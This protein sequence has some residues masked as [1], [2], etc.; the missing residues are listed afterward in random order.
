MI[1]VIA[2]IRIKE[3]HVSEFLEIFKANVPNVIKEYGCIEYCPT[4]DIDADLPPQNL[5]G[6][7]VTIIEKWETLDALRDH[8]KAAHMLVYKE[9]VKDLVDGMSLKVLKEA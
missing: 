6:N 8:I 9:K 5:D 1:N 7:V 3:G 4:I 2:S